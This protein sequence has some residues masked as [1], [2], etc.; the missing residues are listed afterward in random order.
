MRCP[1]K[2]RARHIASTLHATLPADFGA[3]ADVLQ[4]SLGSAGG[5]GDDL[6]SPAA[7]NAGLAGWIVWPMTEFVVH[8][9]MRAPNGRWGRCTR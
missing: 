9:G 3:A 6:A 2:A 5:E 4:A 1:F 7:S 8:R